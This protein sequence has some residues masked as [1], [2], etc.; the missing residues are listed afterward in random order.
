V[1]HAD[2]TVAAAPPALKRALR[3]RDL[4]FYGIVLIQPVAP[5]GIYGV[6]SVEAR[7]HV[8]TTI[9]IGMCAMLLTAVSY[10]R[11]A[12]AYPSAGS[13][14]TYVGEELH[15][16]L[17]YGTGWSMLMDY[18]LNPAI[19]TIW[20]SKA[21]INFLPVVPYPA[22]VV[23]FAL[24]FIAMNLRGIETSARTNE[25]LAI[26]MSV[27]V[28]IFLAAAVRYILGAHLP[29]DAFSRP[30]YDP[31]TFSLK[32]VLTGASIA[33]LT[34]IG[35]DGISTLSEEVENPRRN[36]LLATVLTCLAIGVLAS[37]EVYAAQLVWGDW[38]GFPDLDTAFVHVAGKAGGTG[39]FILI[40]ATLLVANIGSGA[41]AHLG[42]ARLLYGMGRSNALPAFFAAVDPRRNIPRNNVILVG[43]LAMAGG[44]LL[45][46]QLGAELLNF[47][48]FIAFM[49]VNLAALVRYGIRGDGGSRRLGD[50][51]IP[52]GGFIFCFYLWWSLRTP[53]K[54]AG[55]AWLAVGLL[56]GAIRSR[57]RFSVNGSR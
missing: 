56:Y 18:V 30:F 48:A 52:L 12:R 22:W 25:I 54:V 9:L 35:F 31:Q 55:T 38:Q 15:P 20:C 36:I 34:Y 33:S 17:G 21:A 8:V 7:G 41:G 47:G 19:C 32:A 3:L 27:V 2:P 57:G 28:V 23:F 50:I 51:L 6:V 24:L 26:G 11:M 1:A 49:G 29:A 42:A 45:T 44:F 37:I 4:V 10:G 5:M 43:L 14:F 53:A 39:L 16:A 13:A 40:N 46:Y